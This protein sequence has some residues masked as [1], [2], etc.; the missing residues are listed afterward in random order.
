MI[1]TVAGIHEMLY[2]DSV[3]MR[4]SLAIEL[5]LFCLAIFSLLYRYTIMAFRAAR[6]TQAS[7]GVY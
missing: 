6:P 5:S 3:G 1:S 4:M 7:A 2:D